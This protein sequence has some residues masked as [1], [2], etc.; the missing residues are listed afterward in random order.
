MR[1]V[2]AVALALAAPVSA[3]QV[4]DATVVRVELSNFRF[5]P[6]VVNL[7]HGVRYR[8]R[9][10]N[11]GSGGHNFVAREFF[12]AAT[13]SPQDQDLAA[14]GKIELAGGASRDVVLTLSQPGSYPVHCA[15]FGHSAFGMT[16]RINVL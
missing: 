14:S 6:D 15:H 11:T 10:V 2:L 3:Q 8:L 7:R 1:M 13:L 5:T 4:D 9:L 12:A 16:G